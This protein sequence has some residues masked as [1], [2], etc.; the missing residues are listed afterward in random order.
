[1]HVVMRIIKEKDRNGHPRGSCADIPL[2][3]VIAKCENPNGG[4]DKNR[5]VHL[6][7]E[8]YQEKVDDPELKPYILTGYRIEKPKNINALLDKKMMSLFRDSTIWDPTKIDYTAMFNEILEVYGEATT[9]LERAYICS[10]AINRYSGGTRRLLRGWRHKTD[11]LEQ[12]SNDIAKLLGELAKNL[13]KETKNIAYYNLCL[14]KKLIKEFDWSRVFK[15]YK[16]SDKSW[17]LSGK[18][19]L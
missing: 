5:Y 17:F 12:K 3:R 14:D 1:M 13:F 9:R 4:Q 10:F 19:E 16:K 11:E 8:Y 7:R 18:I 2:E 15:P 6:T